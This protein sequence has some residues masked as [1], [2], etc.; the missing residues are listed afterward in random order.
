MKKIYLMMLLAVTMLLA[1]CNDITLPSA[2]YNRAQVV[3]LI[4]LPGDEQVVLS[5]EPYEGFSPDGYHL[6]WGDNQAMDVAVPQATIT[7]LENDKKYTFTVQAVYG[8][9]VNSGQVS[10][11]CTPV[12]SRIAVSGA[13]VTAHDGGVTIEWVR[14]AATVTG[15]TITASLAGQTATTVNAG[16][17]DTSVDIDGL[18]NYKNYTFT[19]V[20]HY[21][22]GDSKPYDVKG[23][24]AKGPLYTVSTATPGLG[25]LHEYKLDDNVEATQVAW[26]F[27]DGA[28]A[29]DRTATHRYLTSG[30][31][32]TRLN[33]TLADGSEINV[34]I[35]LNVRDTYFST[36]DYVAKS[37]DYNGFKGQC[38]AF[39]PDGKT[40]YAVTF[41][42]PAGLY[43]Y[44]I[45]TSQ[46]KWG[47]TAKASSAAYGCAPVVDPRSG[48][49]Y[50][51]TSVA[52]EFYAVNPD[53]SL[54]WTC[55]QM[56]ACNKSFPA[57][58][59][60][61]TVYVLDSGS[62]LWALNPSNG[63]AKWSVALSGA[64][65]GIL[66]NE[67]GNTRT[68]DRAAEII[69]GTK[70]SIYFITSNGTVKADET[71][72]SHAMTEIT[73]FAVSP[74]HRTIYYGTK[75]NGLWA[76][77]LGTHEARQFIDPA[78]ASDVYCPVVAPDGTIVFGTKTTSATATE[79]VFGVNPDM[80]KKWS[81]TVA[82]KNAFNYCHPAIDAQGN[83]YIG[84][85]DGTLVKLN[86]SGKEDATW[87]VASANGFMSAVNI[88]DYAVF[89]GTIGSV[90]ATGR[91]F[92]TY[93]GANRAS[94]WCSRGGDI[95]GTSC[96]K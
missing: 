44:D 69:V 86:T 4:A 89:G 56:K 28:S 72:E 34:D 25:A 23:M 59:S 43:A 29:T 81:Y 48:V 82:M 50:F 19:F 83:T 49:I 53:G 8:E 41:R 78:I 77:S 32:I 16:A 92:G 26:M 10:I 35:E 63:S 73:G 65:G 22:N 66:V 27:D 36:T 87:S 80:S 79:A 62:K 70:S 90:A 84:A 2:D 64:N 1:A 95:C 33:V 85:N 37:G 52:G 7:G 93:V 94:S 18:E 15:Y 55:T 45:A 54:K 42:A 68:G 61:G 75:G 39:S 46:K 3:N 5:W 24:P 91:L 76:V 31:H 51:G 21:V 30:A 6:T 20:V 57:I 14:P 60:D 9:R 96:L 12:T 38:P 58:G 47:C 17:D 88:C 13:T 74:D 11:T 67:S 71:I 40:V